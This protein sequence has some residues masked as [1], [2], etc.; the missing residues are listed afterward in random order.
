M[1]VGRKPKPATELTYELRKDGIWNTEVRLEGKPQPV[2]R[3]VLPAPLQI[4][5]SWKEPRG[6]VEL[7]RTVKSAGGSCKAAGRSFADLS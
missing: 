4:R 7:D 5:S 1:I 3:L 6:G 2:E